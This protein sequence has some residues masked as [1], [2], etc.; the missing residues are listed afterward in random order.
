MSAKARTYLFG[1][2]S[3]ELDVWMA[4]EHHMEGKKL[5]KLRRDIKKVGYIRLVDQLT[6]LMVDTANMASACVDSQRPSTPSAQKTWSLTT[7]ESKN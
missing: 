4:V 5:T 2:L 7:K 3:S 6:S 1:S